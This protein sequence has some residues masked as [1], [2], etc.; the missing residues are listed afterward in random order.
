MNVPFYNLLDT[1]KLIKVGNDL[2]CLWILYGFWRGFCLSAN[3]ALDLVVSSLG[4]IEIE[5]PALNTIYQDEHRE[6][7]D[8]VEWIDKTKNIY[9]PIENNLK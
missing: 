1:T 4:K 7:E 3:T 9:L 8:N 2:I 6:N 5:Y